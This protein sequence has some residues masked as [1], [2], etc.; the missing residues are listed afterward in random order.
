MQA[1]LGRGAAMPKKQKKKRGGGNR[2]AG[3]GN[4]LAGNGNKLSGKGPF[5]DFMKSAGK[6]VLQQ[7]AAAAVPALTAALAGQANAG[8]KKLTGGSKQTV[9]VRA[10]KKILIHTRPVASVL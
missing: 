6:D 3:N 9:K 10:S 7:T 5:G 4:R 1:L 2:L 8:Y